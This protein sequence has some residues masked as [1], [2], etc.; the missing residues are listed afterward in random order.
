MILLL[1][2]FLLTPKTVEE[3]VRLAQS[4]ARVTLVAETDE[5]RL[6]PLPSVPPGA[7]PLLS[8]RYFEGQK[9]HRFGDLDLVVDDAG[10]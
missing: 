1:C 3:A 2:C 4:S 8:F 5:V 6:N 9:R 10:H 7:P